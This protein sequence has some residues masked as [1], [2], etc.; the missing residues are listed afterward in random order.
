[1][2]LA[3][4]APIRRARPPPAKIPPLIWTIPSDVSHLVAVEA[5]HAPFLALSGRLI[6]VLL[7]GGS[8]D[9]PFVSRIN[10]AVELFVDSMH[11][12]ALT[13]GVKIADFDNQIVHDVGEANFSPSVNVTRGVQTA[14]QDLE[15]PFLFWGAVEA[16]ELLSQVRDECEDGVGAVVIDED[17]P[18]PCV[19]EGEF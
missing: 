15:K 2:R 18:R 9:A 13:P 4:L 11:V 3:V 6:L 16:V 10:R 7:D 14:C 12:F 19:V 5:L 17:P 8:C 1:M